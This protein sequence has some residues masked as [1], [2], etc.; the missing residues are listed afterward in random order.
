MKISEKTEGIILIVLV[1][2][3]IVATIIPMVYWFNHPELTKMQLFK[4]YWE[5]YVG[6]IIIYIGAQYYI[7]KHR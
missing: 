2:A 5:L 7:F 4:E 6:I 1:I 3:F